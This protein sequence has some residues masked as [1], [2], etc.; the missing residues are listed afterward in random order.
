[1]RRNVSFSHLMV[2]SLNVANF[3]TVIV[4]YFDFL[5]YAKTNFNGN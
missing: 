2:V 4:C 1:M 3:E 5:I